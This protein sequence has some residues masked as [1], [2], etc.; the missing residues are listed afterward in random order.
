MLGGFQPTTATAIS[1]AGACVVTLAADQF[2]HYYL[3]GYVVTASGATSGLQVDFTITGLMG[4][5]ITNAFVFPAGVLLQATPLIVMFDEPIAATA[6]NIAIVA[7]LPTG[8]GGNTRA[9]VTLIHYPRLSPK[10]A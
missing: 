4:G 2:T 5:T 8:G 7:T 10:R 3:K 9:T 6:Q 1:A